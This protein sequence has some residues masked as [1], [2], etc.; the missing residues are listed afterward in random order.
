MAYGNQ[1]W[2]NPVTT[3]YTTEQYALGTIRVEPADEV[4]ASDASLSGDRIWVF[5]KAGE[6]ITANAIV[7]QNATSTSFVGKRCAATAQL[8]PMKLIG[9][10]SHALT[11]NYYGWVVKQGEV[12]IKSVSVSAG[13][14]LETNGAAR[15][16]A[17][18]GGTIGTDGDATF[19]RAIT[20]T[21]TPSTGLSDAYV[22]FP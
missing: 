2:T 18:T 3:E 7:E 13:D 15:G 6:A 10:A 16:T 17:Q 14:L 20:D 9:V 1:V 11:L 21:G 5:I 8:H 12:V 22:S 4:T 19:G